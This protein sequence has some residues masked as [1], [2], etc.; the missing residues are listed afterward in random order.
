MSWQEN[1]L[2]RFIIERV[3]STAIVKQGRE[4][5]TMLVHFTLLPEAYGSPLC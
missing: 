4:P 1:P 2:A 3:S 5:F